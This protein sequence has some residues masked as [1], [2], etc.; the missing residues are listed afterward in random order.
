MEKF[1]TR[2]WIWFVIG[3]ILTRKAVEYAYIERGYVAFGSEW[4]VLPVVLLIVHFVREVRAELPEMAKML[5]EEDADDR[6]IEAHN[7][8][9][10][11]K[12][13]SHSR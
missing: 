8:R 11:K 13:R 7:R 10:A 5:T 2:N 3:I 9:M 6:R 4:L 1:I 12:R